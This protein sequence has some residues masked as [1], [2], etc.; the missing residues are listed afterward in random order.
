MPTGLEVAGLALAGVGAAVSA[1]SSI[2]GGYA[3]RDAADY[4]ARV[5]EMQAVSAEQAA[6]R[7]EQNARLRLARTQGTV[8]AR[9]AGAGLDIAQGSPLEI[10]AENAREGELD[11]LTARYSG[12]VEASR[13]RS[14]A[15]LERTRGQNAVTAGWMGAGAQLLTAA[16]SAYKLYGPVSGGTA[17]LTAY[18]SGAAARAAGYTWGAGEGW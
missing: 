6:A 2:A 12:Q 18:R 17:D 3:Q 5:A 14:T 16:G 9:A 10:L 11:A 7:E 4:N 13:A 15:A 8:R 1:V